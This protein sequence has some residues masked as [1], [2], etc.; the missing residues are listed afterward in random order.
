MTWVPHDEEVRSVVLLNGAD[1]YRYCIKRVADQQ[2]VWSLHLDDGWALAGDNAGLE[3]VPIWPHERFALLCAT[4]RWAG[5]QARAIDLDDWLARWT[6][7]MERDK[8]RVDV[9]PTPEGFGTVVEPRRLDED[10]RNELR[11]YE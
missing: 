9:F 5:Y 10:L 7:G 1:R 3:C 2:Q 6:S 11:Q 8:R 4:G